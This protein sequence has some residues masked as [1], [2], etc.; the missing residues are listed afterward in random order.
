MTQVMQTQPVNINNNPLNMISVFF[1][2]NKKFLG[3]LVFFILIFILVNR[4]FADPAVITVVGTGKLQ[5]VPAKVEMTVSRVDSSVDPVVA[6]N[7]GENNT[8]LLIDKSKS[9]LGNL[10]IQ[11][12]FYQITPTIVGG[13]KLY[14]VV[15]VFKLTSYEPIKTS[16][17]IKTLYT[18]GAITI[19]NISFLPD[20]QE[21]VTQEARRIALEDA[22]EQAK[23]IA[24]AAGK[25]VGRIVTITDDLSEVSGTVSSQEKGGDTVSVDFSAAA[26]EKIEVAKVVSVTYEIW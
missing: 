19:S 12:A 24:K 2:K 15:N 13:D 11:R 22:R 25:R 5:V 8:K 10:D 6:V 17:L 7:Q 26:P 23:K 14:Q 20:Q 3:I 18:N 1:Q 9:M 21:D 16:E 4:F